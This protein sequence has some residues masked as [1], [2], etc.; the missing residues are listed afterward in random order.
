MKLTIKTDDL[1]KAINNTVINEKSALPVLQHALIEVFSGKNYA[2]ISITTSNEVETL[3]NYIQGNC[4]KESVVFT[5]NVK[6]IKSALFGIDDE[7]ITLTLNERQL[8]LIIGRRRYKI[9]TLAANTFPKSVD[10]NEIKINMDMEA[11]HKGLGTVQYCRDKSNDLTIY[12]GV[13]FDTDHIVAL[14]GRRCAVAPC[15]T[16]LKAPIVIPGHAV[17][18]ILKNTNDECNCFIQT[19]EETIIGLRFASKSF[20]LSIRTKTETYPNWRA[21]LIDIDKA[22][23]RT[24][25]NAPNLSSA[26]KRIM[27]FS[28]KNIDG[29]KYQRVSVVSGENK[30]SISCPDDSADDYAECIN[31]DDFNIEINA[32]FLSDMLAACG[33]SV[34][35]WHANNA[36]SVQAF[37]SDASN[38]VHFIMPMG[39]V[40]A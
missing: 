3:T 4:D 24:E 27:P 8:A 30:L 14:D 31:T 6:Q 25:F 9:E 22:V 12:S 33:D 39:G 10:D 13:C 37:T 26:I 35:T 5:A 21:A 18:S 7:T 38:G 36:Q 16:G 28:L 17:P 34:I 23:T 32:L 40:A 20:S 11:L 19:I 15:M 1:R 29:K 2:D